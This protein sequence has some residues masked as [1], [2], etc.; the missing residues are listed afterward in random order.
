MPRKYR[1]SEESEEYDDQTEESY[2]VSES[3][4]A[5]DNDQSE[6]ETIQELEGS[7]VNED[8]EDSI[9]SSQISADED[10]LKIEVIFLT[11][12]PLLY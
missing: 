2:Q 7:D 10:W 12:D 9:D 6:D 5:S 3:E 1:K 8:S 11:F 4:A